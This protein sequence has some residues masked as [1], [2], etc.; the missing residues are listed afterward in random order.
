LTERSD[1]AEEWRQDFAAAHPGEP[2]PEPSV[3][4]LLQW[5]DWT[6]ENVARL[7]RDATRPRARGSRR[8]KGR[9]LH[10]SAH[11][12]LRRLN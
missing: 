5:M 7:V 12:L 2:V 4:D 11:L 9:E 6:E 10:F 3:Y 8:S 1:L